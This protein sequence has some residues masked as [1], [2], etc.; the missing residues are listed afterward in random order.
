MEFEDTFLK[1]KKLISGDGS[2]IE[3]GGAFLCVACNFVAG[4]V[5][6]IKSHMNKQ[7]SVEFKGNMAKRMTK[8]KQIKNNAVEE[9]QLVNKKLKEEDSASF[10]NT[11][12]SP[13]PGTFPCGKCKIVCD[14]KASY[15]KHMYEIHNR[16]LRLFSCDICGKKFFDKEG[17]QYHMSNLHTEIQHDPESSSIQNQEHFQTQSRHLPSVKSNRLNTILARRPLKPVQNISTYNTMLPNWSNNT[18][19]LPEA[20]IALCS[21]CDLEFQSSAQLTNHITLNHGQG[22]YIDVNKSNEQ[23]TMNIQTNNLNTFHQE[24][25]KSQQTFNTLMST[26]NHNTNHFMLSLTKYK[27]KLGL[28][29]PQNL[30]LPIQTYI[31]KIRLWGKLKIC[32][33]LAKG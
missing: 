3:M 10:Y 22:Q 23:F 15:V 27:L 24:S 1:E 20:C 17:I 2:I 30:A 29:R 5:D 6:T 33:R 26:E 8:V 18:F 13:A 12:N 21:F 16:K 11:S 28:Y 19:T 4:Q 9:K 32:P 7:H 25:R 14:G 31:E